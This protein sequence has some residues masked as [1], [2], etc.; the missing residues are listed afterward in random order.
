MNPI[1]RARFW[2][3]RMLDFTTSITARFR[4]AVRRFDQA[5]GPTTRTVSFW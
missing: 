5:I 2:H 1:L 3:P 4:G